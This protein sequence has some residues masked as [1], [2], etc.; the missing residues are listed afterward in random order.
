MG[1]R[2]A[3]QKRNVR[4]QSRMLTKIRFSLLRCFSSLTLLSACCHKSSLGEMS[5]HSFY[6]TSP[7]QI[8]VEVRGI[9]LKKQVSPENDVHKHRMLIF[10]DQGSVEGERHV[11]ISKWFG[12]LESTFY[13]HHRSPHPDVFRVSNDKNEG[14]T[15]VGRTGWH[16]DGSFQ[17]APFAYS[18]YHMAHVPSQ[19]DTAFAPLTEMIDQLDDRKRERWERLWM[20][21]CFHLGMTEAFIW[22]YDTP[23]Q[24]KWTDWDETQSLLREIHQ[25][26]VKDGGA[27]QYSHKW[28]DGDFIISDNLAVGH[29]ATP[30]TQLPRSQVGLRVLHRT[31]VKGT[32]AP[33]KKY[34][35]RKTLHRDEL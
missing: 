18:L 28:Q 27:I 6:Q 4:Q 16:I 26:F 15:G 31:T 3:K 24:S 21:L 5:A 34:T 8:G 2:S 17:P 33:T 10:R 1:R 30:Q 7:A 25:E 19:G 22:D 11:E 20:T 29:E 35:V 13:K 12:E 9:D 23:E 14:C 32:E